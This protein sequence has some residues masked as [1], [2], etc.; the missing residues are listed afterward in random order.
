MAAVS[1]TAPRLPTETLLVRVTLQE[2][3]IYRRSGMMPGGATRALAHAL[4]GLDNARLESDYIL[5]EARAME[6]NPKGWG[7]TPR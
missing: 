7:G 6:R 2:A 1:Q 3:I 4:D 5:W